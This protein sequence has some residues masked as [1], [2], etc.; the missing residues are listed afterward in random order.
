MYHV[1]LKLSASS[2]EISSCNKDVSAFTRVGYFK[3]IASLMTV[4]IMIN[5]KTGLNINTK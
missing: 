2:G 5:L 1:M 3:A 4:K